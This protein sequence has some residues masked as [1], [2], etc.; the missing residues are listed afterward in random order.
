MEYKQKL[1]AVYKAL[2]KKWEPLEFSMESRKEVEDVDCPF[3]IDCGNNEG[4]KSES[5]C[6]LCRIDHELCDSGANEDFYSNIL[7]E[8]K[9]GKKKQF[10][11]IKKAGLKLIKKRYK[12]ALLDE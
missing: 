1:S 8:I 9:Y 5:G 2:Y 6:A 4:G 7:D 11:K 10:K 12:E 3:C